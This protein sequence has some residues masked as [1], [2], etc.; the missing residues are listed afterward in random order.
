MSQ[1]APSCQSKA[2][3]LQDCLGKNTYNPERCD[4][5]LRQLYECCQQ[6][7]QNNPKSESS[8]CPVPPV[9]DRWFKDHPKKESK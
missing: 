5:V 2:C 4:T 1:E 3:D 9:V 8:A 7:Y 6:M